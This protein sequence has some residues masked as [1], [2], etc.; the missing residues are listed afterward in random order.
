M[1]VKYNKVVE[2]KDVGRKVCLRD[3]SRKTLFLSID[4]SIVLFLRINLFFW[5][6]FFLK[7]FAIKGELYYERN[8]YDILHR[9]NPRLPL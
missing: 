9:R 7:L 1:K 4:T 6:V 5:I 8:H 2:K 3:V